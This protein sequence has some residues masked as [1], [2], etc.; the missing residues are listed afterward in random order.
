MISPI[1][2]EYLNFQDISRV[3]MVYTSTDTWV[4]KE[5]VVVVNCGVL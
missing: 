1:N 2:T 4:L 5:E 3:G